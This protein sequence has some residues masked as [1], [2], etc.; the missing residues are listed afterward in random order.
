MALHH[1]RSG[2]G[3]GNQCIERGK[4]SKKPLTKMFSGSIFSIFFFSKKK[5]GKERKGQDLLYGPS[6]AGGKKKKKAVPDFKQRPADGER[7]G[8]TGEKEGKKKSNVPGKERRARNLFEIEQ[9]G[10]REK[11]KE[12]GKKI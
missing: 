11:R 12:E 3:E 4:R 1:F 6:R 5:R 10:H 9:V 8:D 7:R 2:K